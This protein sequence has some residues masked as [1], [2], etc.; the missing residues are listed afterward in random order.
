M[1][2]TRS[3]LQKET[4]VRYL[5]A[6]TSPGALVYLILPSYLCFFEKTS[7]D[8]WILSGAVA[9][10][11]ILRFTWPRLNKN[12]ESRS[13][14]VGLY[15]FSGLLCLMSSV[16]AFRSLDGNFK[17]ESVLFNTIFIATMTSGVMSAFSAEPI[18][19]AIFGSLILF[20]FT[21][22]LALSS[23]K[24]TL[25]FLVGSVLYLAWNMLQVQRTLKNYIKIQDAEKMVVFQEQ[26]L[27]EFINSLP[28]YVSWFDNELNY[29]DVNSKLTELTGLE[30]NEIVGKN[31]GFANPGDPLINKIRQFK[32]SNQAHEIIE[33]S[34]QEEGQ[35]RH[36]LTTLLRHRVSSTEE[37][38]SV[39]SLDVSQLKAQELELEEKRLQL[40]HQEK[41]AALGEMAGGIAH[42]INNPLAIICGKAEVLLMQKTHGTLTDETLERQLKGINSTSQ[43]IIKIVKSLKNLARDGR[44]NYIEK[45]SV[46]SAI[47]PLIDIMTSR[48]ENMG[49]GLTVDRQGFETEM[50]CGVVELGQVLMN[51]II[52]S[53]QA[54]ELLDEKWVK[55][56]I[57]S[58]AMKVYILISDSGKGI[59]AD[60]QKK[61]FQPFF[62]TKAP[63]MGTGMGLSLSKELMRKQKGDLYYR[64]GLANTTFVLELPKAED[65]ERAS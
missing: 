55:V 61:L 6:N 37:Q 9:L 59:S 40:M 30:R 16:L 43:R 48:L 27:R 56:E 1:Q 21:S 53:A 42:E 24:L 65:S 4:K 22:A 64:S 45:T 29:L 44:I 39:L 36:F 2:L 51:L 17:I 34:L 32:N 52:N 3:S 7:V 15:S 33:L 38:I 47:D 63:G 60:V 8:V 31:L 49:V 26:R 13:H 58:D 5:V 14:L 62:T 18:A 41:F 25:W 23:P 10:F 11:A 28:G 12:Y 46:A 20:P 35:E 57:Q 50:K 19:A 54:I